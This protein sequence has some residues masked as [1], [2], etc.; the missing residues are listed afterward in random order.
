MTQ[1]IEISSI[2]V[3]KESQLRTAKILGVISE[4]CQLFMTADSENFF[5]YGQRLMTERWEKL[6]DIVK[7]SNIFS[8][9]KYPQECCNFTGNY[10]ESH[11]GNAH[12]KI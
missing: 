9:S 8:L 12:L 4:G 6:R 11:P 10:I 3:S 1:F 5:E 7:N 2:G